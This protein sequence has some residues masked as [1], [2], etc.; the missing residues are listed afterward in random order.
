MAATG[1]TAS[2]ACR[3]VSTTSGS[4]PD[5]RRG[6]ISTAAAS[7]ATREAIGRR[8]WDVASLPAHWTGR[9]WTREMFASG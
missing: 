8:G 4:V 6:G 5:G 9:I 7:R 3:T 1:I 2:A